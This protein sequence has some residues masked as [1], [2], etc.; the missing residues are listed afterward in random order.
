MRVKTT[1]LLGPLQAHHIETVGKLNTIAAENGH[2]QTQNRAPAETIRKLN[3]SSQKH[4]K[5]EARRP[6]CL[7]ATGLSS[8]Q[9]D[10]ACVATGLERACVAKRRKRGEGCPSDSCRGRG[11]RKP[12]GSAVRRRLSLSRARLPPS[13]PA[14]SPR[15]LSDVAPRAGRC[16]HQAAERG[17]GAVPEAM[18]PRPGCVGCLAP[19]RLLAYA[20]PRPRRGGSVSRCSAADR[21][22]RKFTQ[23]QTDAVV[24]DLSLRFSCSY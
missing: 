19:P 17:E 22:M 12:A 24:G 14:R 1:V 6:G 8:Q 20:A 23:L 7:L 4:E 10:R 11:E 16:A 5:P 9:G 21:A 15:P 2:S 18:P 3:T 13:L